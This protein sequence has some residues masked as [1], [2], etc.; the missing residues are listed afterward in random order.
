MLT[1]GDEFGRT[2]F[3]N[4]NA[5]AQDNAAF[6]LDWDHAEEDRLGFVAELARLRREHPLLTAETFLTGKGNPPDA[7]WLK[8][9]ATPIV[10]HEWQGLD[11]LC[12]ILTGDETLLIAINRGHQAVSLTLLE[13]QKWRRLASSAACDDARALPARSVSLYHRA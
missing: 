9:D 8:P 4:N 5:Y 2:Q 13:D 7:V 12:L 11:A 3:G 10:D 6:W 1:A